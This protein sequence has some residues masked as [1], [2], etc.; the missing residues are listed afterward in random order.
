MQIAVFGNIH[1]LKSPET[2]QK[3]LSILWERNL[4]VLLDRE[5][6]DLLLP[7]LHAGSRISAIDGENFSAD[8]AISIG[9]DGTLLKTASRVMKKDIPIL[10]INFG[11]L[12]FLTDVSAETIESAV[13]EMLAGKMQTEKRSV[14]QL[15][16][17]KT[18]D[19]AL[20][21][22]AVLKRDGS[23]LIHIHAEVK[24]EFLNTYQADGLIVATPTGSTAYSM[25]VGGP[26]L[27]PQAN[28]LI[29]SPVAPHSLTMRPLVIP[30]SWTVT[31]QVKSRSGSFLVACDGHSRVYGQSAEIHI[32]KAPYTIK[33]LKQSGHTFFN[34][35]KNK[36]M[37]GMDTRV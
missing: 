13:D 24:G 33:L 14:I 30:D 7:S 23:S 35:L 16:A 36:L 32:S 19:Y 11:R 27:V 4:S 37:W 18:T 10:G 21:E 20:N 3:V 6:Y 31:L 9:G 8:Y 5:L 15:Q 17:G 25:S 28:N 12:G 29:I 22:V 1:K 2:L 34:T 26:I